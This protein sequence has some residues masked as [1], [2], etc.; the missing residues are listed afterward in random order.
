M[1][2]AGVVVVILIV[3]DFFP[4][5]LKYLYEDNSDNDSGSDNA[6]AD[7]DDDDDDDDDPPLQAQV[8]CSMTSP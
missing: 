8:D 3:R 7:A 2:T 1:V 5:R 6:D 4:A